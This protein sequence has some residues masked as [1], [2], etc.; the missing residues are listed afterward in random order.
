MRKGCVMKNANKFLDVFGQILLDQFNSQDT[1]FE[2]VAYSGEESFKEARK[3][4]EF[5]LEEYLFTGLRSPMGMSFLASYNQF[6]CVTL[7]LP[8]FA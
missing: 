8:S 4:G 5:L 1:I 2:I 7:S 3:Q 6:V